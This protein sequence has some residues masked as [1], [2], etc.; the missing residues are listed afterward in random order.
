[1]EKTDLDFRH[2]ELLQTSVESINDFF[3]HSFVFLAPL[4][5]PRIDNDWESF[6]QV[7][8]SIHWHLLEEPLIGKEFVTS[9]IVLQL[10]SG[11]SS[12]LKDLSLALNLDVPF[13]PL[14]L[15]EKFIHHAINGSKLFCWVHFDFVQESSHT[16]STISDLVWNSVEKTE[17]WRHEVFS[18]LLLGHEHRLG[19]SG[20]LELVLLPKV[21][22]YT[23]FDTAAELEESGAR[24]LIKSDVIDDVSPLGAVVCDDALAHKLH[25]ALLLESGHQLL[26][27]ATIIFLVNL[28]ID[29]VNP[30]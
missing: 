30:H 27:L 29:L 12:T 8:T 11:E 15:L 16:W 2:A 19:L 20:D 10:R 1:M 23:D 14:G 9:L 26:V 4:R 18:S 6:L 25:L 17:F 5:V 24:A 22:G 28:I 13:S 21:L 3:S 7:I